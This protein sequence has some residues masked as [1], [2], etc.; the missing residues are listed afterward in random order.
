M[1]HSTLFNRTKDSTAKL[2]PNR[3]H[4]SHFLDPEVLQICSVRT[5]DNIANSKYP[6]QKP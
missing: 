5:K 3:Q 1:S 2:H 4:A 6:L